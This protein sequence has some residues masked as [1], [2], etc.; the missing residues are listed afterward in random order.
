[1]AHSEVLLIV[2]AQGTTRFPYT[3]FENSLELTKS[4]LVPRYSKE[5]YCLR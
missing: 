3:A 4:A 5:L 2:S 1:M